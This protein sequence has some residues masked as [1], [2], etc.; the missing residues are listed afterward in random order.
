MRRFIAVDD[1]GVR[2][3]PMIVEG[4][5]HG[6]LAEGVGIALMQ[7][8]AFD[9][10]GNCLERLVHGLPASRRSMEVP[11]WEL[12][13]TVTPSPHHP[14]GAKGV[15]RVG[16]RRLAAGGRQRGGRR[17]RSR[18]ACATSTCRC[19]P[20]RV[21]EAMQ[22]SARSRRSDRATPAA[23][24]RAPPA[25]PFVRGDGRALRSARRARARAT[26]RSCSATAR[27]R[28]SSAASCADATRAPAGAA[29]ARDRRAR[30]C[31]G[32]CPGRATTGP[33]TRRAR[34]SSPTRA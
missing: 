22:G 13:E 10:E 29:R 6:G 20:A 28:A 30:C 21:W 26:A 4:Q 32:S 8:I 2:I 16:H 7:L 31:C 9:E 18:S 15:G 27:S 19:T 3:N 12:G 17:A 34:S 33:A 1:C 11:D 25:S 24:A 5:I 23:R 14:I